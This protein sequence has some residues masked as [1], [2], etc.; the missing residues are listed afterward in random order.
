MEVLGFEYSGFIY[1]QIG[2]DNS[3]IPS[4]KMYLIG[5]GGLKGL[6]SINVN[7][8]EEQAL[9]GAKIAFNMDNELNHISK[10]KIMGYIDMSIDEIE[11]EDWRRGN[12]STINS[13]ER[14]LL[15]QQWMKI[16]H[17]EVREK[18]ESKKIKEEPLNVGFID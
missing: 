6:F 2:C 13:I 9:I 11:I 18:I 17:L 14:S 4:T 3:I 7:E 8:E 1:K 10:Y 12:N 16:Q 5:I 15:H